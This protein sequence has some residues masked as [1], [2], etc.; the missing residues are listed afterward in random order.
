MGNTVSAAEMAAAQIVGST[1]IEE[2]FAA[3]PRRLHGNPPPECPM[4]RKKAE[5]IIIGYYD[6][7]LRLVINCFVC[8]L[9]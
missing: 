1:V 6:Q 4:H 5:V 8:N 7:G 3:T 2:D 9:L